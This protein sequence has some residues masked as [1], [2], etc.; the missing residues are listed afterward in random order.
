MRYFFWVMVLF[1]S[2]AYAEGF[3]LQSLQAPQSNLLT[4]NSGNRPILVDQAFVMTNQIVEHQV[5]LTWDIYGNYYLY[6]KQFQ[7]QLE[8]APKASIGVVDFPV[9]IVKEDPYFGKQNIY[10][11]QVQL[12]VP[13]VGE[14]PDHAYLKVSYQ[15][16]SGNLCY[17][18][19]TQKI[20][21]QKGMGAPLPVVKLSG[22]GNDL[23]HGFGWTLLLLFGLGVLLTFTPCVLPMIPILSSIIVGQKE[24]VSL[25]RAAGLSLSYVL[26]MAITYAIF[27]LIIASVGASVQ[28]Y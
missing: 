9:A 12:T 18:P 13:I 16:C 27:G 28:G 23:S 2:V 8:G 7:F 14:I 22:L 4:Q 11:H 3:D 17:P 20:L 24:A 19:Q 5:V 26:G 6:Q 15:G 1:C 21:L 25:K 10:E